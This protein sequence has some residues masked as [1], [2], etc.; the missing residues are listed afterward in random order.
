MD[1]DQKKQ[2]QMSH[3][4]GAMSE[5]TGAHIIDGGC[6]MNCQVDLLI[7]MNARKE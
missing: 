2:V 7:Q 6:N 4:D 5:Q 1:M 3:N